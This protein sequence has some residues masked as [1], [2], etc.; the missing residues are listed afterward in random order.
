MKRLIKR[1]V[2]K[3]QVDRE[4]DEVN[5]GKWIVIIDTLEHVTLLLLI[6]TL[7]G[8]SLDNILCSCVCHQCWLWATFMLINSGFLI[9]LSR[10]HISQDL[11]SALL[12]PIALPL[13]ALQHAGYCQHPTLPWCRSK[14]VSA[15]PKICI[16]IMSYR[17]CM[18]MEENL[19]LSP[20]NCYS[21]ASPPIDR[22]KYME[23]S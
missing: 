1:Y 5:E 10:I 21:P 18:Q 9:F 11:Y 12:C 22:D 7:R 4:N 14:A 19:L 13:L 8:V 20:L 15:C 6:R 16:V 2:L 23:R 17:I 3:A